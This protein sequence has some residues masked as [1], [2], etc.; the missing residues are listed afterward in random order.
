MPAGHFCAMIDHRQPHV[1]VTV[2]V[3]EQKRRPALTGGQK[4]LENAFHGFC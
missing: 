2:G 3:V 4:D 1:D